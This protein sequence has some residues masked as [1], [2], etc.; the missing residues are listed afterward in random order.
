MQRNIV[1]ESMNGSHSAI[2]AEG[3]NK[4]LMQKV[5]KDILSDVRKKR[6]DNVKFSQ[7]D[8]KVMKELTSLS[9]NLE[10]LRDLIY[11]REGVEIK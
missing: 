8:F 11:M 1:G 4:V 10:A 9:G 3:D 2:T 7:K 6:H 5:V